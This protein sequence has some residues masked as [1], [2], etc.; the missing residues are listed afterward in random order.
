MPK[1]SPITYKA[2]DI[3][4]TS[5]DFYSSQSLLWEPSL[6]SVYTFRHTHIISIV[7]H[8]LFALLYEAWEYRCFFS[9]IMFRNV[10]KLPCHCASYLHQNN[11][12]HGVKGRLSH[13]D[14]WLLGLKFTKENS[15]HP[16]KGP[17]DFLHKYE[18]A[19]RVKV[20]WWVWYLPHA[21]DMIY[22]SYTR[23]Y[24]AELWAID[25]ILVM[26]SLYLLIIVLNIGIK[27]GVW[28]CVYTLKDIWFSS[29]YACI[30]PIA[31]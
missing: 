4:K 29:S 20:A 17:D 10:D 25:N 5:R 24:P 9:Y 21:I 27:H 7:R 11:L 31:L 23:T 14:V 30:T 28:M 18:L 2:V 16:I 3:K 22:G 6:F 15:S 19:A 1:V 8:F 12:A 13:N 26:P